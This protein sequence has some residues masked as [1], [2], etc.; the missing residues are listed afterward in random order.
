MSRPR[1]AHTASLL[2]DGSVL[3]AGGSDDAG[4]P[5]DQA[6]L[7]DPQSMTWQV[8]PPMKVRRQ[9]H[10]ATALPNGQVV[11]AGGRGLRSRTLASVE[12]FDPASRQWLS[13]ASMASGRAGHTATLLPD[14]RLLVVA[15]QGE[16]GYFASSE[17]FDISANGA[18]ATA[19]TGP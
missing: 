13:A 3:V 7:F 12:I 6:E 4:V 9:A 11:V 17:L 10:T 15:G 16:A 2:A 8:M 19:S 1:G 5:T 18:Q 14:G